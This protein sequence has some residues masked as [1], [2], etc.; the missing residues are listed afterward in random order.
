MLTSKMIFRLITLIGLLLLSLLVV[1]AQE[2]SDTS[3]P[4]G[5]SYVVQANDWLSKL[6]E[7]YLGDVLAYDQIVAATNA[8]AATDESYTVITNPDLI[9]VGQKLWIPVPDENVVVPEPANVVGIYKSALPA[10]TCCG[11]DLTLY[12]NIDNS[13]RLVTDFLNNETV[14]DEVGSWA[15]NADNQVELTLT[16]QVDRAYDAP[17]VTLFD[18]T[19]EGLTRAANPDTPDAIRETYIPFPALALGE[20]MLPYDAEAVSNAIAARGYAGAYKGFLPSASCCGQDITLFLNIDNSARF[21]TDYLNGEDAIAE[22]GAWQLDDAERVV[23]TLTGRDDLVY[24]EATVLTLE[25]VDGQL[26]TIADED[27][28]GNAGLELYQF[29][30]LAVSMMP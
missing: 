19:T 10:A 24:D 11:Q 8:K 1:Q 21:V 28:F 20:A 2:S 26:Q 3:V 27:N 23:V 4:P 16:G 30:G 15:I 29:F 14:I 13:A 6:A 22:V 12:L 7:Q 25:L 17:S 5:E 9:E 18:Q